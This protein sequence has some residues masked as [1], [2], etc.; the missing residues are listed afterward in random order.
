MNIINLFKNKLDRILTKKEVIIVAVI[1]MPIM[2]GAA[3]LF[4]QKTASKTNIAVVSQNPQSVPQNEKFK[5]DIMKKKPADSR[6]IMGYYDFIAVEKSDGSYDITT[7]IK[8]KDDMEIIGK[9]FND[10]KSPV[11]YGDSVSKRGMGT[12][13][14]GFI[15]MIV[16]MQGVAITLLYPEDRTLKT[17]RRILTAP[18]SEKEY[19]FVQGIFTFVCLYIPTYLA[20]AIAKIG[21]GVN[22]GFNLG[23]LLVLVAILIA[24]AT[25]FSLFISSVLDDNISLVASGIA[26]LT[27][28]LAGCFNVFKVNKV[29]DT[30]FSILPQKSY[31]TLI[32][33][34]EN[35]NSIFEFKE[36]L[37]YI[38]IWIIAFWLLGSIISKKK[39]NSGAY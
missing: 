15:I 37:V 3:V 25:A 2:I 36:H 26:L 19:V 1:I 16:L 31:M 7:A 35:G 22:M 11:K 6:L 23:M 29:L 5:L 4:S 27:S 38:L 10:G 17:F 14:L 30:I 13:I 33:G 39:M 12:K 32:Q 20:V 8:S 21:F 9:F 28:L 34:V 18:V 24:F